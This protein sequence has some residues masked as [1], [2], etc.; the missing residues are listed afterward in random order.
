LPIVEAI[1]RDGDHYDFEAR[2]EIGRTTSSAQPRSSPKSP[3]A[4]RRSR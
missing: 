3:F 1:P 4:R 2:Y